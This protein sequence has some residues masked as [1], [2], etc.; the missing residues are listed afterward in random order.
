MESP[1][2]FIEAFLRAQTD[3]SAASRELHRSLEARFFEPEYQALYSARRGAKDDSPERI[4][5]VEE[6]GNVAKVITSGP[7]SGIPKRYRYHLRRSATGWLIFER[8]WECLLC[9]G[10][11]RQ[12]DDSCD[13]CQGTGW[14]DSMKNE[15]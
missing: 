12:S 10:S 9:A 3:V 7:P 5:S 15:G 2:Q 8:E 1:K 11:G 4:L 13:I 6:A 14:K